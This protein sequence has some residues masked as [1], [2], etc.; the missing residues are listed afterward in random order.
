MTVRDGAAH[1]NAMQ[2]A[3]VMTTRG[4]A[5]GVDERGRA[6]LT[7]SAGQQVMMEWER[8]YM[9]RCVVALGIRKGVDRVLEVGFG[10]AYSATHIQR[11][12]PRRHTIIE[13]DE[14]AL[15]RADAFAAAHPSVR[16]VRGTWQ[17]ALPALGEFDCVF[18][19]DFPLP[20]LQ[21]SRLP[22]TRCV[23]MQ[24]PEP[25]RLLAGEAS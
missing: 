8:A 25:A 24:T 5:L 21:Q 22:R 20:E 11:F 18:F 9:E 6:V 3:S 16:V 10:L 15:R 4:N 23:W 17:A 7:S 13:C 2:H 12:G 1:K 19:D 14:E